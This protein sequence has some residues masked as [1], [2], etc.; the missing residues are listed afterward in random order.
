IFLS[1]AAGR[2]TRND[3]WHSQAHPLAGSGAVSGRAFLDSNGN[4]VKEKDENPI[5]G[6]GFLLNSG[7][8]LARTDEAGEVFLPNLAP[9]QPLDLSLATS[10]L[11]DPFWKPE[12]DGVRIVP[13]PGKVALI[14]F[15]VQVTG[16]ITGT[17]RVRRDGTSRVASGVEVQL[18]DAAGAVVMAARSEYDGF[19]DL[20][21]IRPGRYTLR[22][23]PEEINRHHLTVLPGQR[24]V[25]MAPAGPVLDGVDFELEGEPTVTPPITS[26]Y[27]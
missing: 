14:D 6:V 19:Y 24:E 22:I 20:V 1:V 23:G 4:G 11:E 8:S 2:D 18:L 10:T 15:P 9:D 13:R 27:R 12:R 17:V 26:L 5:P 7:G 25:G 21:M 3:T 16:E